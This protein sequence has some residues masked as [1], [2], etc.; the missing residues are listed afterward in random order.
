MMFIVADDGT[1]VNEQFHRIAEIVKD[2][3]PYLE[4]AWIPEGARTTEEEKKNPYCIR[5]LRSDSIVM[6]ISQS[7]S[8]AEV[9]ERLFM[10]D[11]KHGD[12]LE[13]MEARNAANEILRLKEKMEEEELKQDWVA[14]LIGNKKN[15]IHER[16][17]LTGEKIKFDDQLRRL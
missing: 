3:D 7:D 1:W 4:L 10:S 17:P 16:N 12:V 9:L 11:N 6:F 5:D 14:S 8:P 13:R 2:Y 15:Y